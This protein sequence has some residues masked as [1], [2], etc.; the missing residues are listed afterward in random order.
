MKLDVED[1]L[2]SA[3]GGVFGRAI[4]FLVAVWIGCFIGSAGLMAGGMTD[5]GTWRV[6]GLLWLW[7]GP[8]LLFSTWAFLNIP[9]LLFSLIRFVRGDGDSY[10]TWGVVIAVESLVVMLSWVKSFV[11]GWPAMGVA[12]ATW[13]V[14][15]VMVGTG[16]WLVR[17]HLINLW[18]R[19]MAMLRAA[20]AQKRAEREA[21]ERRRM[22]LEGDR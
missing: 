20:N 16:I 6:N 1:V 3:I 21:E 4:L 11:N 15:L 13:L 7:A 12:W 18:A 2:A 9:F 10:V 22:E 17:Q 14:L 5:A 19:D 8:L